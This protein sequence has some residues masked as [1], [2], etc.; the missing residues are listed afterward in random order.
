MAWGDFRA[1][2][3]GALGIAPKLHPPEGCM[4][5]L[6][7]APFKSYSSYPIFCFGHIVAFD[8]YVLNFFFS[9]ICQ[10]LQFLLGE[11]A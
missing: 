5:L 9:L 11:S 1:T 3:F 6:H 2:F 7:Y 4:L 10:F 8:L